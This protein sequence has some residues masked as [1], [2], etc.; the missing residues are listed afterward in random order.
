MNLAKYRITTTPTTNPTLPPYRAPPL[1]RGGFGSCAQV[2][3]VHKQRRNMHEISAQNGMHPHI[4]LR[5]NTPKDGKSEDSPQPSMS[6]KRHYRRDDNLD[7]HLPPTGQ[8]INYAPHFI[9]ASEELGRPGMERSRVVDFMNIGCE[10]ETLIYN[11]DSHIRDRQQ[12]I[13]P[14]CVI[15]EVSQL[16]HHRIALRFLTP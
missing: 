12:M 7:P 2:S 1:F 9:F 4:H 5:D 10:E 6:K 8:A 14:T 15:H 16:N 11:N 3:Y 13:D